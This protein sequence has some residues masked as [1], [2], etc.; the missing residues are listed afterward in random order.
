MAVPALVDCPAD[1]WTK[2]ADG[3]TSGTLRLIL[4]SPKKYLWTYVADLGAAPTDLT[5]AVPLEDGQALVFA[6]ASD[7]YV[8][9]IG[10]AGRVRFDS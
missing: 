3:I 9:A 6:D 7:V 10:A 1:Q 5:D 8:Y 4:T 2:V